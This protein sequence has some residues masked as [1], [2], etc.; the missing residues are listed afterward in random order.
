M[1]ATRLSE[2]LAST[3]QSARRLNPK[4]LRQNCHRRENLESYLL[5]FLLIFLVIKET[6]ELQ[7]YN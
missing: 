7:K 3:D 2:T 1:E 6:R 4:E 5:S